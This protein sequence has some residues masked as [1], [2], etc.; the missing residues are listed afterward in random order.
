MLDARLRAGN[1]GTAEGALDVILDVVERVRRSFCDVAMVLKD[2]GFPSAA[3]PAGLEARGIDYVSRL[4][5]TPVLHR[6]AEPHMVRPVARRPAQLR[7]WL[8]ELRYQADS[9]D[10]PRRVIIVVKEREGDLLLDRFFL[11]TSLSRTKLSRHEA[12][13]VHSRDF[14]RIRTS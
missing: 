2:A 3:L 12:L 14:C 9:W 10:K 13:A 4:R 6:L 8:R 1:V 11:V 7:A 5:S